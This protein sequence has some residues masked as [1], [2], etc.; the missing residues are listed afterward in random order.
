MPKNR[1]EIPKSERQAELV[2]L[3]R[4]LFV[5]GGYRGTSVAA[6]GRAAGIAPAAVHWYFPTKDDLFAA[7][8]ASV[9]DEVRAQVEADSAL[10]GDP[11]AELIAMLVRMEPYRGLH[12]VAYERMEDNA[13]LRAVYEQAQDWLEGRLFAAIAARAGDG[14]DLAAIT[15]L[16][17]VLFEGALVSVRRL[18]RPTGELVDLLITSLAAT[19]TGAS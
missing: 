13:T 17:H 7:V 16:A 3:A 14:A 6:V 8:I 11:R 15:D 5:D 12:R 10:A 4:E 9:F 1:Q 19:A 2:Q 18:D